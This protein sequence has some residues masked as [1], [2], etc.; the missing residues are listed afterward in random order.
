MTKFDKY[1]DLFAEQGDFDI[2]A[3]WT[4]GIAYDVTPDLTL[5]ADIQ[6]IMY[7]DIKA[8]NNP[9]DPNDYPGMPTSNASDLL[10]ILMI[11]ALTI[12]VISILLNVYLARKVKELSSSRQIPKIKP[13]INKVSK[14]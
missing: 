8:I 2:P 1:R 5:V 11:I 3:N 12:S 10:F 13:T 14:K 7:S 6:Q 4:A 9:L